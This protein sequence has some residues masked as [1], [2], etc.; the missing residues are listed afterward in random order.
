MNIESTRADRLATWPVTSDTDGAEHHSP[1]VPVEH[2]ALSAVRSSH[3]HATP[4]QTLANSTAVR[5]LAL[6]Y[7]RTPI[8]Q[9]AVYLSTL[10]ILWVFTC[11]LEKR[12]LGHTTY[13]DQTG[14]GPT[15]DVNVV[16]IG[17]ISL[18]NSINSV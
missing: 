15:I 1:P 7:R 6:R 13:S 8:W 11:I 10:V 5:G 14:N 16:P 3:S 9:L 4:K 12:P 17:L 2:Q 18:L